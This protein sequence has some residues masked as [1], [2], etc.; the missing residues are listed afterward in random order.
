M[1]ILNAI[2]LVE[3]F[4]SW[5]FFYKTNILKKENELKE[6]KNRHNEVEKSYRALLDQINSDENMFFIKSK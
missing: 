1:A 3:F 4:F 2:L 6:F 5:H